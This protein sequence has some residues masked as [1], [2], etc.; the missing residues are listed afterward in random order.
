MKRYL[1]INAAGAAFHEPDPLTM[2]VDSPPPKE[3]LF[4]DCAGVGRICHHVYAGDAQH[5]DPQQRKDRHYD[6]AGPTVTPKSQDD[7]RAAHIG[8][9]CAIRRQFF[10]D[11]TDRPEA[12]LGM[13]YDEK[14]DT[15]SNV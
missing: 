5:P 9:R 10:V 4:C 2:F 6:I 13:R 12:Q 14:T 1:E 11:V 3:V 8:P 7:F 15:F